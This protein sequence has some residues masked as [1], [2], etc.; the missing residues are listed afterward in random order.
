MNTPV[1]LYKNTYESPVKTQEV[2]RTITYITLCKSAKRSSLSILNLGKTLSKR[3][4][5]SNIK[6]ILVQPSYQDSTMT[7]GLLGRDND[8]VGAGGDNCPNLRSLAHLNDDH[9]SCY[10][11]RFC[12]NKEKQDL[13][14]PHEWQSLDLSL[15]NPI[16]AMPC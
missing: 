1:P 13:N 8:S 12:I 15:I 10:S 16:Q 3:F 2:N 6:H 7:S 14:S 9:G 4:D 11:T 5:I